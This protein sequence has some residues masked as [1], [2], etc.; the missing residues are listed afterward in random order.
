MTA[1]QYGDNRGRSDDSITPRLYVGTNCMGAGFA[2]FAVWHCKRVCKHHCAVSAQRYTCA[3][4]SDCVR[5]RDCMGAIFPFV[6]MGTI[7]GLGLEA[8]EH[9]HHE[10]ILDSINPCGGCGGAA[11]RQRARVHNARNFGDCLEYLDMLIGG[12][13]NVYTCS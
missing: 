2:D 13:V 3:R 9:Y 6:F 8:P 10:R 7:G 4:S 12:R 5:K 11:F 1:Q